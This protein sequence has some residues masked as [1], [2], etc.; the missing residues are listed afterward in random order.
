[1][2]EKVLSTPLPI[3]TPEQVFRSYTPREIGAIFGQ[4]LDKV[5]EGK[6]DRIDGHPPEK[7]QKR[8]EDGILFPVLVF[9]G[10]TPVACYA[11]QWYGDK[12]D[13]G[14]A[15][16][17]PEHRNTGLVRGKNIYQV[18]H[19]WVEEHLHDK[20]AIVSG[21]SRIPVSAAIAVNYCHRFPC[22]L[23]PFPSWGYPNEPLEENNNRNHEFLLVSESYPRGHA[24]APE[25]VYLP[26]DQKASAL[27]QGLWEGFKQW[28]HDNQPVE[29]QVNFENQKE[30][31]FK[32]TKGD[33]ERVRF[34]FDPN[35]S[36]DSVDLDTAVKLCFQGSP[37]GQVPKTRGLAIDV[38]CDHP[39]SSGIQNLLINKGFVFMGIY[40]GISPIEVCYPD[41]TKG[42]FNRKPINMYG[43]M[44]PGLQN[45][46]VQADIPSLNDP[47]LTQ[48]FKEIYNSWLK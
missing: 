38:P 27:I 21:G 25:I 11:I 3:C 7:F 22:W 46:I 9:D 20:A 47:G 18:A 16:V 32:F 26:S 10:E 19:Q 17:L 1:M 34:E 8:I 15:A 14:N 23:P 37:S 12:V 35:D 5:Y 24:F 31:K 4:L 42:T 48:I 6:S 44:R 33:D 36:T 28:Q 45:H 30:A 41:G 29:F 40:P 39:D 13:M 2:K 43:M